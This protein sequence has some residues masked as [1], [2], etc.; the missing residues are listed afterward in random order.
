M[1]V[2]G[3]DLM[4]SILQVAWTSLDMRRIVLKKQPYYGDVDAL[5]AVVLIHTYHSGDPS[6]CSALLY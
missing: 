4:L 1:T 6:L 5:V 2:E 3:K